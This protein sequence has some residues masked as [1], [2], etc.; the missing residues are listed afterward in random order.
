MHNLYKL[1]SLDE[2]MGQIEMGMDIEFQIYDVRYNISWRDDKPFICKCPDGDAV[3]Y[4][5]PKLMFEQYQINGKVLQDIWQ[6]FE[7]IF[8]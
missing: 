3:F 1:K 6:D 2:L 4:D 5:T 7:I 8:M